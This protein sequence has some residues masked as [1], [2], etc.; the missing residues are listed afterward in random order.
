MADTL[1]FWLDR[2]VD[3]FRLDAVHVLGKDPEL[4]D[5]PAD[6]AALPATLG[7]DRPETHD[8]LAELR[9][10][11]DA[12]PDRMMVGEVFLLSTAQVA[13][14]YGTSTR[15]EL[16]LAF[17]FAPLFAPWEASA[18]RRA[19][20]ETEAHIGP[21]GWPAWV[22]SNH[23]LPRHRSRY[24]S[25]ARARAAAVLLCTLRGTPFLYAGEELGLGDA[26]VPAERRVDPGGRDG[27][28]A[29]LPWTA[30]PGHGWAGGADARPW[31]PWPPGADTDRNVAAEDADP[32]SVLCLYRRLLAVR[33]A[34]PALRH[35][36]MEA[37]DAGPGVL[38]YRRRA[39][40]DERL[41]AINFTGDVQPWPPALDPGAWVVEVSSDGAGGGD[42]GILGPDRAVVLRPAPVPEESP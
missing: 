12:Y 35:G 1:R 16:N 27:Q 28:R 42:P 7:N 23:D 17:N 15:P 6:V 29:P 13:P 33:R 5:L 21:V 19:V 40:G 36:A 22:L 41:V 8:L 9:R 14:Y 24:G 39:D 37:L 18:W 26:V 34:S 38:A 11:V 31:L 20:D 2:G 25:D 32:G 3:G 30:E 4:G 10:V